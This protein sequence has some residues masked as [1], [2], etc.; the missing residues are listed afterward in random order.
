MIMN[1]LKEN[2]LSKSMGIIKLS[3]KSIYFCAYLIY[4]KKH[5]CKCACY[6]QVFTLASE[7]RQTWKS[8]VVV[9][10]VCYRKYG[11]NE[12]D[13]PMFTQPLMYTAI[14]KHNSALSIYQ[15]KLLEDGIANKVG[16]KEDLN[17]A[18]KSLPNSFETD[19][20]KVHIALLYS[21]NPDNGNV[22]KLHDKEYYSICI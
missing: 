9:D 6:L 17:E 15:Q 19:F 21:R 8:D 12:I 1:M 16:S 14:K 22:R 3:K 10:I 18:H 4:P 7:W 11:H 2:V 5:S 13:E 20:F